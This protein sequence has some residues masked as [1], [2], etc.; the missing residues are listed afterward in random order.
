MASNKH[1]SQ[2]LNQ[3]TQI[4]RTG[5]KTRAIEYL[6]DF[7][8]TQPHNAA[9]P[10]D[11]GIFFQQNNMPL[12]AEMFYRH[13]LS[14]DNSQAAIHFNLGVIYQNMGKTEQ[15]IKAYLEAVEAQPD[16]AR[17]FANLGYLYH[18][19]GDSNKCRECCLNAQHLEPDNPQIKHMIAALGVNPLPEAADQQYIK[20]LYKE[21]ADHYDKHLSVT[22][23]SRVPELIH[24]ATLKHL[25]KTPSDYALLDLGCGTGICGQLFSQYT[26]NM[27]GVDLSEE[28][29]EEARKKDIYRQLYT[30]DIDEYLNK[31][32][33]SHGDEKYDIIISSDVLI[34]IGNL[35]SVIAGAFKALSKGGL[36]SFSIESS[37]DSCDDFIL[38]A[39]GRYKHNP[40]YISRISSESNF[41]ILSSAET[42][43]REQNKQAVTGRIYVLAK[44]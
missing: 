5:N 4:L 23:K 41:N 7:C 18:E 19:T 24:N 2:I 42:A 34:Y 21:Y 17:A 28:M 35:K 25:K 14:L 8:N 38:D 44:P 9:L 22:L 16:Y 10:R 36:F 3:A 20:N 31:T 27:V 40:Q 29:I 6:S 12:K 11:I 30:S 33:A 15:A 43:L 1:L 32:I 13:S 26:H 39:T 37:T